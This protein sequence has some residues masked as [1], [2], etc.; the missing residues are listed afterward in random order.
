MDSFHNHIF[1]STEVPA[2]VNPPSE[3]FRLMLLDKLQRLRINRL[4]RNVE[5]LTHFS[6]RLRDRD[7]R[8]DQ[9]PQRLLPVHVARFCLAAGHV[10]RHGKTAGKTPLSASAFAIDL[11]ADDIEDSCRLSRE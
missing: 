7:A 2:R 4:F 3:I 1:E 5:R 10:R 8:L 11:L 6:R 9:T